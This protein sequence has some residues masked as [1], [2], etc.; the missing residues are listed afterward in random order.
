MKEGWRLLGRSRRPTL[1]PYHH[2]H[3]L[4]MSPL[5]HPFAGYLFACMLAVPVLAQQPAL[6]WGPVIDVNAPGEGGL[7]PRIA[8]N[9][10]GDPVVL[11]GRSGP[12]ANLVAVW[13]GTSFGAP[14][15]VSMPGCIPSVAEWMGSGIAAHGNTLWV[16]MK[17]TP[18]E[19]RPLYVRRSDDG[20]LTW[21]DTLRVDPLDDG[22]SRFPSIAVSDAESPVVQYMRFDS[23]YI[24]ARQVT[25]RLNGAAFDPPVPVSTPFL[26]GDVC[27]C[28]PSQVEALGDRVVALYRHAEGNERVMWG[29][30][31]DDGG[32]SFPVGSLLD[33]TGWLLNAC[34]SSGPDGYLTADSIRYVWMSG[35]NNG[36]KVYVGSAD[37]AGLGLGPQRLVHPGQSIGHQQGDPRIAG[38]A[39]TV[40][41]VWQQ[42]KAGQLEVLFA[43]ST[44]GPGGLGEPDTVN[45]VLTGAQ[46]TP[47]I[48]YAN[49]NFHVIW[50]EGNTQVRYRKA[51]I[52]SDVG[53]QEPGARAV[54][55][56]PDPATDVLRVE[57]AWARGEVLDVSGRTLLRPTV[58]QGA[59]GIGALPPGTYVLRL[60]EVGGASTV[61]TFRKQQ[62]P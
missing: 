37:V 61:T 45:A 3:G 31:S 9:T 35:A 51:T 25:A 33:T 5:F 16:V 58:Q 17:A 11:W 28:C 21:G 8:L 60:W 43:W 27:D 6:T 40:G 12:A 57:G 29:A 1:R 7:R 49:G 13:N 32:V 30:T 62:A 54:R 53:V 19:S 24:G 15:E 34:P 52:T 47:D 36:N 42:N 56:W 55:V 50:S 41:I 14:V 39:D 4:R 22:V 26:D 48:A 38:T 23:G 44:S 2:R 59:I 20:G 46:R 18:E 10:A